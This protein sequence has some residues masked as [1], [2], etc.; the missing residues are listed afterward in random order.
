MLFF[1]LSS[2]YEQKLSRTEVC[3]DSDLNIWLKSLTLC[4]TVG[5]HT[6]SFKWV[7]V[8]YVRMILT[9]YD[10]EIIIKII[11]NSN[12]YIEIDFLIKT[13]FLYVKL[14]C[15][16]TLV[17]WLSF[18][19]ITLLLPNSLREIIFVT[20]VVVITFISYKIYHVFL[21]RGCSAMYFM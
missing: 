16:F 18:M 10:F 6:C 21:S 9:F 20:V 8:F 13:N 12:M 4:I 19:F 7:F 11:F 3:D 5:I 14:S 2:V 15:L 1:F 17:Y